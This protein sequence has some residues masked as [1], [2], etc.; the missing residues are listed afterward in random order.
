MV[1]EGEVFVD[2]FDFFVSAVLRDSKD[3]VIL[4]G[5]EKLVAIRLALNNYA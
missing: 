3:A 5:H 1:F 2:L 4:F